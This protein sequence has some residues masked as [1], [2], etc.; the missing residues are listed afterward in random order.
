MSVVKRHS[1]LN[2]PNAEPEHAL[3][4]MS[5]SV[6]FDLYGAVP[7]ANLQRWLESLPEAARVT[8][9]GAYNGKAQF[10][11]KWKENR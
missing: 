8:F 10:V 6:T 5:V 7:K 11:A 1:N 9:E 3:M 2:N 4:E